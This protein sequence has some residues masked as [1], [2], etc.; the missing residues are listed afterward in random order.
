MEQDDANAQDILIC[1]GTNR[2]KHE[3][4]RMKFATDQ[5]YL[6]SGDEMAELFSYAPE[7]ITN[8]LLIAQRCNLEIK[9][10]G[11]LLPAF[12]IP[13]G[14]TSPEEYLTYLT[15]EGL[16][17]RYE[18]ITDEIR[19][20]AD[21]ELQVIISMEFTGY[22][23]IVW[24]FIHWAKEH[25]IPVGPGR[26]SGAGSIVAYAMTITDIDPIK[27]S[28]LFERFLNPERVSMPD[29]DI[30]FCF[31]RRLEVVDYVSRKYGEDRVAQIITFGTLKAKAVIKDVA[32]VLDIPFSETNE[33]SKL[34]P[35]DP[36]M[37]ISKAMEAEPKLQ[38]L[39]SKGGVYAELFDVSRR[40]EGLNR[41]CSTHAAGIVI[42]K[43][44]LTEYVPLYRDA[45][46]G[47]IS[48]QYTMDLLEECGW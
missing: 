6:K 22:F 32:R 39:E 15:N 30:D 7:A 21:F 5:F 8:T 36:K 2:K 29:F 45:K 16:K 43:D 17:Q 28:L 31:E 12:T 37:T 14:F 34:I 4:G 38:Q 18:V 47:S 19:E 11:P 25:D 13:E 10:P 40:L 33:I 1:I 24:D 42:G 41:H 3:Q 9:F 23:L 27:Y 44:I 48:T 35:A 20:R 26:G 46:T